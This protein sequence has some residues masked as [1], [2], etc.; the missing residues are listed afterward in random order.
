MDNQCDWNQEEKSIT[1]FVRDGF[2]TVRRMVNGAKEL[3]PSDSMGRNTGECFS[4]ESE[5]NEVLNVANRLK[6]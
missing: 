6:I 1:F 5:M 3:F 2:Y 4:S